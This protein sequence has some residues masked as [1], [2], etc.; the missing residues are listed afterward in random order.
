MMEEKTMQQVLEN[1]TMTTEILNAE[2]GKGFVISIEKDYYVVKDLDTK[3][4]VHVTQSNF[5][6]EMNCQILKD[7]EEEE[8]VWIIGFDKETKE[9]IQI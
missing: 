6:Y 3:E 2:S 8:S 4:I 5:D 1:E 7:V 9:Y